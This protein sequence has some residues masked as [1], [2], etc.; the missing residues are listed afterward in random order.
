MEQVSR[1]C[2]RF[3]LSAAVASQAAEF[4]RLAEVRG[5]LRVRGM[6]STGLAMVCLEIASG[7]HGEALDKVCPVSYACIHFTHFINNALFLFS[8]GTSSEA[9][10]SS[11]SCVY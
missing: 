9:V 1:F 4:Y 2:K 8:A 3:Q 11:V 10:R 7:H 5:M 6:T